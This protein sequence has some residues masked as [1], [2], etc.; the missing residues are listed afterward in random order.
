MSSSFFLL[1]FY[2]LFV[3]FFIKISQIEIYVK[4][5]IVRLYNYNMRL[6]EIREQNK[7]TQTEIAD[8]LHIRQNTYS[9]YENGQRQLPLESLIALAKFYNTTTDYILGLTDKR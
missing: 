1:P 2:S 3:I 8:F 4:Y 9:Q 5:L 7:K 6:K